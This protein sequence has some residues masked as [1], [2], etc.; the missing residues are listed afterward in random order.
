VTPDATIEQAGKLAKKAKRLFAGKDPDVAG[1]ALIELVALHLAGHYVPDD[2]EATKA[3]RVELLLAFVQ[4]VEGLVP[5][6]EAME[7][8]PRLEEMQQR[9]RPN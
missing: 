9:E 2:P 6:L 3:I 5:V 8:L 4:A 7:I 1:A